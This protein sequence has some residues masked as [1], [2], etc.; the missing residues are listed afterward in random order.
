[1]IKSLLANKVNADGTTI[2]VS[3]ATPNVTATAANLNVPQQVTVFFVQL[4]IHFILLYQSYHAHTKRQPLL[5]ISRNVVSKRV[6]VNRSRKTQPASNDET[7]KLKPIYQICMKINRIFFRLIVF[8]F[9]CNLL[10]IR[11]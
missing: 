8:Y 11:H 6:C 5:I 1:M 3:V 2:N 7:L 10:T 9:V 4:T